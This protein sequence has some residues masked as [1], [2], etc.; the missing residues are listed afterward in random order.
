MNS[1]VEE[2]ITALYKWVTTRKGTPIVRDTTALK[3]TRYDF[4]LD[5]AVVNPLSFTVFEMTD[6]GELIIDEPQR[7][8]ESEAAFYIFVNP[9]TGWVV[10]VKNTI[11]NQKKL[12]QQKAFQNLKIKIIP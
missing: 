1:Q 10:A 5:S 9:K 3:N 12:I 11:E 6:S 4:Y 7:V 2:I 8:V